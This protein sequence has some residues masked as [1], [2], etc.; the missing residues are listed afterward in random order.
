MK[1]TQIIREEYTLVL[2][3]EEA[4]WLKAVVQNPINCEE[5]DK[6]DS[7]SREMRQRFWRALECRDGG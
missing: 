6:E 7:L 5:L 4:K 1:S 3:A 2:D